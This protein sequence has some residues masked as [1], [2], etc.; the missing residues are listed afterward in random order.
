MYAAGDGHLE[1]VVELLAQEGDIHAV[2]D[3][4]IKIGTL[5]LCGYTNCSVHS[6]E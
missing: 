4:S 6:F 2:A 3:V 1:T 5:T